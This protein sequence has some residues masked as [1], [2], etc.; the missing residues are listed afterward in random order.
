MDAGIISTRYAR[1]ILKFA[2]EK[3][4]ETSIY[5]NMQTLANSFTEFPDLQKAMSAPMVTAEKKI[6]LLLTA[7]G[8]DDTNV[9]K[10]LI[11]MVVERGR[12]N[13]M[14]NIALVYMDVYRKAKG[15]VIA[16]L[17]TVEPVSKETENDFVKVVALA[18]GDN[19]EF[20]NNIDKDI[21][22]GFVLQIEDKR[23][24][25]SVKDQLNKLKLDLAGNN[26]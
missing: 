21:I 26:F 12:A 15:L 8:K 6:E 23:L 18:T 5:Q 16:Q 1:A 9:L 7:S 19:V 4:L 17:T 14:R 20:H 13:Y 10:S 11:R 22:G 3:S 24:D 25:A 2:E